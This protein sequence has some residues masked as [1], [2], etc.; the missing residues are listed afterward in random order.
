MI[1]GHFS[2]T[3]SKA[4][5][6]SIAP[7]PLVEA[8]DVKAALNALQE[9]DAQPTA[10]QL[11]GITGLPMEQCEALLDT[12]LPK[13]P[14]AKAKAKG[15]AKGAP[16]PKA[17]RKRKGQGE[18]PEPVAEPP[19][20]MEPNAV[21]EQVK[22]AAKPKAKKS[23]NS[24]PVVEVGETSFLFLFVVNVVGEPNCCCAAAWHVEAPNLICSYLP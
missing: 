3:S 1:F 7:R 12:I 16:K 8:M 2:T 9:Q 24:E 17:G 20:E 10:E 4:I 11:A 15:C 13:Q 23:K 5:L 21:Q 19:Q 14:K 6:V 22:R 18:D